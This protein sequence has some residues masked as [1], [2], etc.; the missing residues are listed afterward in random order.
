MKGRPRSNG[1]SRGNA[2]KYW[3][4]WTLAGGLGEFP[5]IGAAAG[6]AIIFAGFGDVVVAAIATVSGLLAGLSVGVVTGL[7]L[8]RPGSK[9]SL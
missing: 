2:L 5:G 8:I 6:I 7:F 1:Y 9:I 4:K 3:W